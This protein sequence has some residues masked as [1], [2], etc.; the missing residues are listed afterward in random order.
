MTTPPMFSLPPS[1][2]PAQQYMHRA[3]KFREAAIA[4]VDYSND[5]QFLPKYALLTH[6]IE[7]SLKAFALYSV[8]AGKPFRR[9]SNHDLRGLYQLAVEYGL[10]D[11]PSISDNINH[12]HDLH[13]S[14]YMRY[15]QEATT[16]VPNLSLIADAT[17]DYLLDHF[18]AV[19]NPR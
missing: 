16:P 7:L 10:R 4:L 13:F 2:T 11:D 1:G 3:R 19:I 14:H 12:L 18:T 15:P 17:V 6:A 5:E 9:V 8:A